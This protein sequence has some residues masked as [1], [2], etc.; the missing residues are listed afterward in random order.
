MLGVVASWS[1]AV[2]FAEVK[3][4]HMVV[5]FASGGISVCIYVVNELL[6]LSKLSE[7]YMYWKNT[8]GGVGFGPPRRFLY[9]KPYLLRLR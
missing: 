5:L 9:P 1:L 7:S 3:Q 8:D 4:F 6:K 2:I